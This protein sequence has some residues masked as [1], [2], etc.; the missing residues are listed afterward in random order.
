MFIFFI[1][2]YHVLLVGLF[3]GIFLRRGRHRASGCAFALCHRI[4]PCCFVVMRQLY[5]IYTVMISIFTNHPL[6]QM[7]LSKFMCYTFFTYNFSTLTHLKILKL[8]HLEKLRA[9]TEQWSGS[10]RSG[11]VKSIKIPADLQAQ[12]A[13]VAFKI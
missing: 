4:Q 8:G 5:V 3:G 1:F 2:F 9:A 10:T 6:F 11:D 13:F 7:I 12:L